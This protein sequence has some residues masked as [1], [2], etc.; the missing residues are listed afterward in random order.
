MSIHADQSEL[1]WRRLSNLQPALRAQV[2]VQPQ[3]YRGVKWFI[4]QDQSSGRFCRVNHLAYAFIARLDGNLTVAEVLELTNGSKQDRLQRQEVMSLLAHLHELEVL[5]GG[6]PLS[7][8]DALARYRNTQRQ[9]FTQSWGNPL[10]IRLSLLDPDR[11]LN[12]LAPVGR[13]VFS[14]V[15]ATIW[16]TTGL[17]ALLLLMLHAGSFAAAVGALDFS[18]R[19]LAIIVLLYPCIKALHELGHG[20]ATK[21]WGGEVHDAGV[22]FLLFMPVPYVD[23]SASW[24]FRDRRKRA[25]VAAAGILVELFLAACGLIVWQLSSPGIVNEIALNTM[26]IAGVS[27]LLYNGNPLLRFDGYF[28]LE[29]LL[30]IP[31]LATRSAKY[32]LYLI[33]RYVLAMPGATSPV[34][35]SGERRWFVAYGI[36]SPIYRLFVLI[37][38][39]V[40]LSSHFLMA[41]VALAGWA[42]FNQLGKPFLSALRFLLSDARLQAH[43]RRCH[44]LI[45]VCG[46][47][48]IACLLFPAPLTSRIEG[49]VWLG[50]SS[51]VYSQV[52]GVVSRTLVHSGAGVR[53]GE[54]VLQLRNDD[55]DLQLLQ[56]RLNLKELETRRYV[57]RQQSRSE[58][59]RIEANI[60]QAQAMVSDLE[61]R[62]RMLDV[63]TQ[64]AGRLVFAD[65]ERLED[66]HV[67]SGDVIGFVLGNHQP[68]VRAV[69]DQ[70]QVQRLQRESFSAEVVLSDQ[71]GRIHSASLEHQMPA[72]TTSLPS[73][74]LGT[75]GGGPIPVDPADPTGVTAAQP[76][77]LLDLR[78]PPE[79][80]TSVVG[81]RVFVKLTHGTEPLLVQWA[82]SI[83]QIFINVLPT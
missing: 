22:M 44:G 15:G 41:G 52:A 21:V 79:A 11:I 61:A 68:L 16:L 36:L 63:N 74:A 31:N 39:A 17:V 23:A 80:S 46:V 33:Q 8:S 27:T 64:T 1:L 4:I 56:A 81:Q 43:R 3:E 48:V 62:H 67:Q 51:H 65:P 24:A 13:L 12:R 30:Q 10:A 34:T 38:I 69:I 77:Y 49:V 54:T 2:Q 19:Q 26:L 18:G 37:G 82:R 57:A 71:P 75:L 47:G 5:K 7:L 58:E 73:A 78:L 25:I 14:K 72:A 29:D 59:S 20:M 50:E 53:E 83:R 66:K 42:V 40:Y 70:Q 60:H 55:L 28:V 35:A 32:L 76:I 45:A 6:I 9:K